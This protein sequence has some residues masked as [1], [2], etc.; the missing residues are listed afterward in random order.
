MG[1]H[2]SHSSKEPQTKK[3]K[4]R[5]A[6]Q[7]FVT[8]LIFG[9]LTMVF[10]GWAYLHLKAQA[11]RSKAQAESSKKNQE[12]FRDLARS[13]GAQPQ[14]SPVN[15]LPTTKSGGSGNTETF[16]APVISGVVSLLMFCMGVS[17]AAQ[18][19]QMPDTPENRERRI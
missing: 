10:A 12:L 18:A 9:A 13:Q 3:E 5:A 8:A 1:Y 4:L 14:P 11:E 6:R 19:R 7:Y 2:F 15:E 17:Y 16:I